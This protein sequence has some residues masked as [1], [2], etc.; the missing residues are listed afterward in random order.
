MR[1]LLLIVALVFAS[2]AIPSIG[3]ACPRCSHDSVSESLVDVRFVAF[4]PQR[5]VLTYRIDD[6]STRVRVADGVVPTRAARGVVEPSPRQPCAGGRARGGGEP[7]R[8]PG[9]APG[10]EIVMRIGQVADAAQVNVQT[11]RYY[12][13]RGILKA[14]KRSRSGYREYDEGV[15]QL[16]VFI[17]RAQELGFTL[18]ELLILRDA[19]H[20][21][22]G[23]GRR[24]RKDG[25]HRRAGAAAQSDAEG[26]QEARRH[27]RCRRPRNGGGR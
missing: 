5:R 12:E 21:R 7:D 2:S 6:A 4:D 20:L 18:K 9:A 16:V 25:R 15:V 27:M 23:A 26:A 13:R 22:R 11:L 3:L 14:P 1:S 19:G 8:R 10:E 24:S 17:K